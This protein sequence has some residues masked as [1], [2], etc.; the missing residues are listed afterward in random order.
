MPVVPSRF[1]G[2][3]L[4]LDI[5]NGVKGSST[6][7]VPSLP[8]SPAPRHFTVHPPD[9]MRQGFSGGEA[10][11]N[12]SFFSPPWADEGSES[13]SLP[14]AP[15][16]CRGKQTFWRPGKSAD[17]GLVTGSPQGWSLICEWGM[18]FHTPQGCCE[19]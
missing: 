11:G 7:R 3:V 17:L 9:Q 1:L 16:S 6:S 18:L 14:D 5:N 8:S 13:S 10:A 2:S 15:P 19:N 4:S 12:S